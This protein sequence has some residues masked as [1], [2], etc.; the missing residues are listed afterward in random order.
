LER[1]VTAEERARANRLLERWGTLAIV[2]TRP[3]PLLAETV[4][5][6]AGASPLGWGRTNIGRLRRL[7]SSCV[8]LPAHG[9]VGRQIPKYRA[10]VP[11]RS[12]HY[13]NL[14]DR[15]PPNHT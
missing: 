12:S 11:V 3:I 15:G 1:L 10:D 7:A 5:I 14:L 6:M 8:A 4:A 13:R 2:V 9:S